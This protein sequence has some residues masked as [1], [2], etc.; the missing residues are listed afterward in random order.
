MADVALCEEEN[1]TS[2][3]TSSLCVRVE[4]NEADQQVAFLPPK[5]VFHRHWDTSQQQRC[6]ADPSVDGR[7]HHG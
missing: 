3:M 4:Q 1:R 5:H 7:L 6:L 2:E